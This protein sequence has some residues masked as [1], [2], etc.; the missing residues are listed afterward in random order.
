MHTPTTE[1]TTITPDAYQEAALSTA[2][3]EAL[4]SLDDDALVAVTFTDGVIVGGLLGTDDDGDRYVETA[5]GYRRPLPLVGDTNTV[6]RLDIIVDGD[7]RTRIGDPAAVE[8]AAL[9]CD[10]DTTP[11]EEEEE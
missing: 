9:T 7:H 2:L 8:G 1:D 5:D 11:D 10:T 3:L 4:D 6:E